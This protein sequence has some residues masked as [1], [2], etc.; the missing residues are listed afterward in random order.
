[1]L[2]ACTCTCTCMCAVNIRLRVPSM[3]MHAHIHV[4]VGNQQWSK[5][6]HS[7]T[8]Q[9]TSF[10]PIC[11][12]PWPHT[13]T[14]YVHCSCM[15]WYVA[16]KPITRIRLVRCLFISYIDAKLPLPKY[17]YTHAYIYMYMHNMAMETIR[18]V[19]QTSDHS[20]EGHTCATSYRGG[21]FPSKT[22]HIRLLRGISH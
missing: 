17:T 14:T 15:A 9:F 5:P 2:S 22:S 13:G 11:L 20:I 8:Q 18:Q 1:M 16:V 3:Y 4:H 12:Y 10:S 6:H 21:I 19:W 7:C